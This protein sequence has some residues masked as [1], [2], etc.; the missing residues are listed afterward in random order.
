MGSNPQPQRTERNEMI[1]SCL[2]LVPITATVLY[3]LRLLTWIQIRN[4][5]IVRRRGVFIKSLKYLKE[6]C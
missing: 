6:E 2:V 5:P 3:A 1:N 4:C